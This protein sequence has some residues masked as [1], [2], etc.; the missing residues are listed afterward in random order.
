MDRS[1]YL[2]FHLAGEEYAIGILRVREII[3]L[4]AV[5]KVP[6]MPPHIRGVINLRGSVV[7]LV[8][9]A[10]RFG[11]AETS[12]G[13]RTCV[14]IVEMNSAAEAA[15]VG[16]LADAVGQVIDLAGKDILPTPHFG[17]PVNINFLRGMARIA[18]KFVLLLD[19]DTVVSETTGVEVSSPCQ[20]SLSV[21]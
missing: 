7:P 16:V 3:A 13:A 6:R 15:T 4:D 17:T 2:T 5:T 9:L 8:D 11:L 18:N 19:I 12:L 21:R 10:A 20:E 1:Q 14:V